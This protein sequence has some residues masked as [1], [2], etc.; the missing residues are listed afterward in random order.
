[1]A[2][3]KS[4]VIKAPEA[5]A[6]EGASDLQVLHPNLVATLNGREVTVREYGFVEG[7]QLQPLLQPF[8]D[9]LYELA[10]AD[11]LP[12]MEHIVALI[13]RHTDVVLEAIAISAD[14]KLEELR[15]LKNQLEGRA[16]LMKWWTANGP[17]FYRC[18]LDRILAEREVAR[19]RAG[20][21]SMPPS[22]GP[23]TAT[24]SESAG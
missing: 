4:G 5:P 18:V 2:R 11:T 9:G 24:P 13:G 15:S 23:A 8:L 21:T 16:L 7:L 3:K 20:A 1:M 10:K 12:P 19:R 17:F 22:S 14:I 6:A